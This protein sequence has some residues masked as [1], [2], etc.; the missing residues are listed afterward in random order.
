MR[1]CLLAACAIWPVW[2]LSAAAARNVPVHDEAGLAAAI[3]AALPGDDIVLA[4]GVY[5]IGHKLKAQASGSAQAP[6]TVRAAHRFGA[7]LRSSGLIAVEVTG[8]Y[9]SFEDL[10]IRGVC[11]Q[12]TTCEHAFHVVGGASGFRLAGSRLV[13]FNAHIKVNADLAHAMPAGG[14]IENTEFFDSHPRQTDNPVAP[15]NIDN[16]TGWIVRH[17]FIHDFQKDGTGEGSYGAF[18]KG[19]STAPLLER[20]LVICARDRAAMGRMVGLSFGAHGMDPALCPPHWDKNHVCNPE[21]EGGTMRNNIVASC[22]DDGIYLNRG[23]ASKILFNTLMNT[24]GM[25]FRFSGSTGIARG[26]LLTGDIRARDGGVFTNGGNA[27]G[28]ASPD[29]LD[30]SFSHRADAPGRLLQLPGPDALVPDD[31]C[32]RARTGTL[33]VGARQ[34]PQG[35]CPLWP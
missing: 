20:N 27:S 12:D 7:S 31:Y 28:V 29:L 18:V 11:A 8:S 33:D 32:G 16:A 22:N 2:L 4:D 13:D 19:G 14:V 5:A 30:A 3:A 25:T 17:N 15:V 6:I 9:W 26:N 1:A 35:D 34:L 24:G 21:V 10:D 23:H